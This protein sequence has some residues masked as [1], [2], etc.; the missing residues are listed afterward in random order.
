MSRSIQ[1]KP[2]LKED[3]KALLPRNAFASQQALAEHLGLSRDVISRFLNGKPVDR[4][5]AEEICSALG[6]DVKEVT[7]IEEDEVNTEETQTKQ[8]K[9]DWGESTDNSGIFDIYARKKELET[10]TKWIIEDKCRL[11][12]IEG[13]KGMG[14]THL[15]YQLVQK[16][17]K[18]FDFVILRS[19]D[20]YESI[21]ELLTDWL[22]FINKEDDI[23]KLNIEHKIDKIILN[24]N[25]YRCLF[26][27][28][29]IECKIA[30][31]S[32]TFEDK[33]YDILL[34]KIANK[35]EKSCLVMTSNMEPREISLLVAQNEWSR[36]LEIEPLSV[37]AIK[38]LFN[39]V[40]SFEGEE[41]DWKLLRD[42]YRGNPFILVN[43]AINI[44]KSFAGNIT[45]FISYCTIHNSFNFVFNGIEEFIK[46][47][48]EN[49]SET[50]RNVMY[51]LAIYRNPISLFKLKDIMEGLLG[52]EILTITKHLKS[53]FFVES[54]DEGILIQP[55]MIQDYLTKKLINDIIEEIINNSFHV[56]NKFP[57]FLPNATIKIRENQ[58]KFILKPIIEKLKKYF[59]TNQQTKVHLQEILYQHKN[60]KYDRYLGGNILNILRNLGSLVNE[61]FS[62]LLLKNANL[63]VI[64]LNNT[65]FTGSHLENPMFLHGF[66]N[67]IS[68]AFSPDGKW[69][70]IGDTNAQIYL[71]RIGESRPI[72]HHIIDSNNFW[73]RAIAFSPDSKII[74]SGG[75][76]GNIHL[77]E[78]E[79]RRTIAIFSGHLDRIRALSYSAN[80]QLLASSSD[81]RTV[82]IWDFNRKELITILTKHQDKVR[83]V[84]FHPYKD[85]LISASQDNQICLWDVNTS[86]AK[87]ITLFRLKENKNNL[88]RAIAVSPD[89][90]ILASGTDDGMLSLWNLETGQFKQS[91]SH[92]H[93]DWIISLAFSPNGDQ[94]ASAS[95]DTTI[96]I[97]DVKTGKHLHTLRGHTGRVWSIDFHPK[98]PWLVSGEMGFNVRIWNHQS[99]ECLQEFQGYTQE[100]KPITYSP[101]GKILAVGTNQGIIYLKDSLDGE[102]KAEILTYNG[103]VLSLAYSP[104]NQ[105]LIG[106]SD[107][108]KLYIWDTFNKNR[109]IK[110][111]AEHKNWIRTVAYSPDRKF[112]ATGSDDKTIKLWDAYTFKLLRT[113]IGHT[114]L[115]QSVCFHPTKPLLI[116]GSNDGTIRLWDINNL[117][118]PNPIFKIFQSSQREVWTVAISPDG[119]LMASGSND[120]TICVWDLEAENTKAIMIIRDHR[121]WISSVAFSPDSQWLASGS[122]D[123][124]I[125]LWKLSSTEDKTE[126]SCDKILLGHGNAVMCVIFHPYE[127]I[128]A[129]SSKDGTIKRWNYATGD[130][131]STWRSPRPY[132]NMDI[133]EVTGLNSA[134]KYALK[135]LGAIER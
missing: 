132:E 130:C 51:W 49:L 91:L 97:S 108:T 117:K 131:L 28:I 105:I 36:R 22:Y 66:S 61:D 79:T 59:N 90:E 107:D 102:D 48:L 119:N 128:L 73:V 47:Q 78:V 133:T 85:T 21:D 9:I 20:Q 77:W 8:T 25:T 50:E 106:G 120:N 80:G 30:Q 24:Y 124:S 116:S 13:M 100:I 18:N 118:N 12:F 98:L 2:Q 83:W 127:P 93:N 19:L 68:V 101:N 70:A 111:L 99:G 62:E 46:E 134:Q 72:L 115:I 34:K 87:L 58:E 6:R 53:R 67:V 65:D 37:E 7:Y 38:N 4:L 56:L 14:Q 55:Q 60:N 15:S 43:V 110:S 84:I 57:L 23:E 76:D 86:G 63:R 88:L 54:K 112:M 135:T 75:E 52:D 42:T 3:I 125:R 92:N 44:K 35:Q 16:N 33:N 69:L 31:S 41:E 26:I 45:H 10:L 113:C 122:Y 114:D 94:I 123:T 64:R 32:F 27:L 126:Y 74:S 104:D 1:L 17:K 89:G 29:N 11:I 129:S 39:R 5:N 95:E 81:D 103:N 96:C 71:W 40:G 82:R 121:H 109:L